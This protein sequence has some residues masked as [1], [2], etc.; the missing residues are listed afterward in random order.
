[1]RGVFLFFRVS[2]ILA[3]SVVLSWQQPPNVI[4][5]EEKA[6]ECKPLPGRA[7]NDAL[8]AA[9]LQAPTLELQNR[10]VRAYAGLVKRELR[11][12]APHYR[13]YDCRADFVNVGLVGLFEAIKCF[14]PKKHDDFPKFARSR[15]RHALDEEAKKLPL[16]E[17]PATASEAVDARGVA[18]H[19]AAEEVREAFGISHITLLERFVFAARYF[20]RS[21]CKDIAAAYHLTPR[22]VRSVLKKAREKLRRAMEQEV[23]MKESLRPLVR[24]GDEDASAWPE[25][26]VWTAECSRRYHAEVQRTE[27]GTGVLALFD[28]WENDRLLASWPVEIPKDAELTLEHSEEW[29]GMVRRHLYPRLPIPVK[30]WNVYRRGGRNKK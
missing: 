27:L 11:P 18:Q 21:M 7:A 12:F 13:E 15:I 9:Y 3:T 26:V 19:E 30:I 16:G 28:H 10:L 2:S 22:G 5:S 25:K 8:R 23:P 1:M 4:V 29:D 20:D 6:V 14:D 24:W 17:R